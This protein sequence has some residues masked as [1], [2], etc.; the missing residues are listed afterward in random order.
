MRPVWGARF[1]ADHWQSV[2]N[3]FG[4]VPRNALSVSCAIDD[5][6]LTYQDS[7]YFAF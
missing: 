3:A 7:D 1:R 2:S 5:E 4:S 6:K